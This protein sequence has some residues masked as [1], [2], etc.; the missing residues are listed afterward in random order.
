MKASLKKEALKRDELYSVFNIAGF[1][2]GFFEGSRAVVEESLKL[3]V[4]KL[5]FAIS[6][7]DYRMVPENPHPVSHEDTYAALKYVY[8]DSDKL[9]ICKKKIFVAGDSAGE[10][11]FLKQESFGYDAK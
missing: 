5:H 10:H 8:E 7:V 2:I 1:R 4:E 9:N 6:S 3:M 11:D